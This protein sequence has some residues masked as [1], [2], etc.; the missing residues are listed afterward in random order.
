MAIGLV[1]AAALWASPARA[2]V[3]STVAAGPGGTAAFAWSQLAGSSEPVFERT[4]GGD[5]TLG[6]PQ[7]VSYALRSTVGQAIGEDVA[8]D[9]VIAWI[10]N[11][12]AAQAIYVRER[13]PDG[14]LGAVAPVT[15]AGVTA[16][17]L[18]MAVE[19]DGDAFLVWRRMLS[20]KN[21]IQGRRRAHGGALGPILTLSYAGA[22][23]I[24]PDVAVTPGGAAT[25][26]WARATT[27]FKLYVQTRTVAPDGTLS[28]TQA[29]S[30]AR[31]QLQGPA[32]TVSDAGKAVAGWIRFDGEQW[33]VEARTRAA[34]GT[35][36]LRKAISAAGP[37]L[38]DLV[39]A[40]DG[41][42]RTLFA[43][44]ETPDNSV[45]RFRF[46]STAGALGPVTD[47][48]AGSAAEPRA[49]FD[50][51]GN[52]ILAWTAVAGDRAVQMRRRALSGAL[53]TVRTVS[54]DGTD[55]ASPSLAV[56]AAGKAT[57]AWRL[58]DGTL[59]AR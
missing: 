19:P 18:R 57:I 38:S 50:A 24:H 44:T 51:D 42:G 25:V 21:V 15:P 1:A 56:D 43:W 32:V 9:A 20:G 55:S 48:T 2:S 49:S 23:A 26:V 10:S 16:V 5:G 39:V 37:D 8:G 46:R 58:A 47:M 13:A 52:A 27:D 29:L 41:A 6:R 36:G 3:D 12:A 54:E 59:F 40:G 45:A 14:T 30:P 17:D 35:L 34:D 4:L 31:P 7:Q 22:H 33:M 53:G 28:A 11:D